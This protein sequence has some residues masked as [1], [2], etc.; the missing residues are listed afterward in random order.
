MSK[1]VP[2]VKMAMAFLIMG[3]VKLFGIK[4]NPWIAGGRV[5]QDEKEVK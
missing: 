1:F 3:V 4:W 2:A 5:N